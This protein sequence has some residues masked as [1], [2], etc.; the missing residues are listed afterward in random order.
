MLLSHIFLFIGLVA[1]AAIVLVIM[2]LRTINA[3][4]VGHEKAAHIAAAIRTG[5]M[6]FLKEEYRVIAAVDLVAA[7]LL[8][9]FSSGLAAGCF[10]LGSALSLFAGFVGMRAAT[11]A[12]VRTTMA[13]RDS[14]E[15]AA[16]RV[17]FLGGGV[18]GFAVAGIGLLGLGTMMYLFLD[19]P[20]FKSIITNF[21]L[22]AS[23]VAFFAR[24]GG[25]IYT[26]SADVGADL[27]GKLE[28][29]IPEDDPRNPAV[30]AD[31]VGDCVGD[32]FQKLHCCTVLCNYYCAKTMP[33]YRV[34]YSTL[35]YLR[36]CRRFL[37]GCQRLSGLFRV[38]SHQPQK[39][40]RQR[41]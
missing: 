25:G 22:G 19:H 38:Y 20:C 41:R 10:L 40:L 27:V 30:I 24:V 8:F 1:L 7:A 12:N 17:A 2:L 32:I 14:G 21:G 28:A 16:F 6:T 31:N 9:Y 37:E 18:M 36:I 4:P 5:A 29:G 13:A 3:L 39:G 33:L 11:A 26:K 23:F 34:F 15:K 35:G